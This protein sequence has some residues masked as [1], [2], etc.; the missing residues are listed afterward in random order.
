MTKVYGT[1]LIPYGK[2]LQTITEKKCQQ[3]EF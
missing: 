3:T 2:A 1:A